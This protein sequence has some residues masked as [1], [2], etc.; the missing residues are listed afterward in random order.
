MKII[1]I[2]DVHIASPLTAR[3]SPIKAHERSLE[4]IGTFRRIAEEAKSSGAEAMMICGDLFDNESVGLSTLDSVM[5]IIESAPRVKFLYL[6]GNHEKNRLIS[7]GVRIPENLM[8]FGED[9]TYF[10]IGNVTFAGRERTDKNMFDSLVLKE[11][12]IN[13]LVMHGELCD[14]SDEGGRI[15]LDRLASL[16][17]DYVAL[18]HY[19]SFSEKRISARTV[20]VYSG[21]PEGRGFDEAGQ[22]GFVTVDVGKRTLDYKFTPIAKRTLHVCEVD[23]TGAEREIEVERKITEKISGIS[24]KDLLR[25]LLIGERTTSYKPDVAA[26]KER[27]SDGYYFF[28]VKDTSRLKISAEEY[29][30]DKSLKGEFIRLVLSKDDLTQEQKDAI[31]ECGLRALAGETI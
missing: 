8:I 4:I 20:A 28:E 22:K 30:N 14:H 1:H 21:T 10:T 7:S 31:I 5:G 29:K 18:G 25:I 17:I 11:E 27:F 16:P 6:P 9:W 15:G 26:I 24:S 23:I 3:L 13:I 19:H 12:G 2:S